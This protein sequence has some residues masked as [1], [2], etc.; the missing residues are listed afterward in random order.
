M[1]T[2]AHSL[3][4]P[5][6]YRHRPP[7]FTAPAT[8]PSSSSPFPHTDKGRGVVATAPVE[9]GDLLVWARP[10]AVLHGAVD[11]QPDAALLAP[12][13][14]DL[15]PSAAA[16]PTLPPSAR[17][18]LAHL[19]GGEGGA[20]AAAAAAAARRLPPPFWDAAAMA[21][22][23]RSG[24]SSSSSSS[25]GTTSSSGGDA[26]PPGWPPTP[27]RAARLLR[28]NA[29][30]DDYEDLAAA[31]ARGA[32]AR[33]VVGVW[34]G[35]SYFNHSCL[36]STVHYVV[37]DGM[38]VRAVT[39]VAAGEEL[40]VSYL[41]REEFAPAAAR[42]AALLE[43]WGFECRCERCA[44]EAAAPPALTRAVEAAY[45]R[46]MR[47]LRPALLDA[48]AAGD[49]AR[50]AAA[51]RGLDD[52]EAAVR[53]AIREHT[54]G[55]NSSGSGSGDDDSTTTS[56]SGGGAGLHPA[57]ATFA[58]AALYELYELQYAATQLLAGGDGGSLSDAER[59]QRALAALSRCLSIVDAVS[60]GAELH[61]FLAAALLREATALRGADSPQAA[62]ALQLL[63]HA[64]EARYGKSLPAALWDALQRANGELAGE[65]L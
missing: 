22:A 16:S 6:R 28:T 15:D 61:V 63:G 9:L 21:A 4:E 45:A 46:V 50:L 7:L 64:S 47:D 18:A 48:A 2:A 13:L 53:A 37:N 5:R 30:G 60:R 52:T 40:T 34:P 20:T 10:A 31:A 42:R 25:S 35:F 8:A 39:D 36:P 55:S 11:D 14:L 51:A 17:A 24:S 56:S 33:S 19:D 26:S 12:R 3:D 29:F 27:E 43:R 1:S 62:A 59:A 44:V 49:G 32:G 58:H 41:G 38:L 23:A 54:Q 65:Y 57:T